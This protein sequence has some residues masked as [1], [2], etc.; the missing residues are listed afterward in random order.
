MQE[1]MD[2][3]GEMNQQA[4]SLREKNWLRAFSPSTGYLLLGSDDSTAG[5]KERSER[6]VRRPAPAIRAIRAHSD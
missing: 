1:T 5:E 2:V 3:N 4:V 6:S